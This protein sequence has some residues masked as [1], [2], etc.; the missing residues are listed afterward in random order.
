[1]LSAATAAVT[2]RHSDAIRPSF[3]A[4]AVLDEQKTAEK[5]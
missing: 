1:L 4:R 5:K 3:I 2:V